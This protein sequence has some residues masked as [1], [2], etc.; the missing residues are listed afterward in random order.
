VL[1][2]FLNPGGIMSKLIFALTALY[3][4]N[5]FAFDC[6]PMSQITVM[7]SGKVY[8]NRGEDE[9]LLMYNRPERDVVRAALEM[10]PRLDWMTCLL[11]EGSA[12]KEVV[13]CTKDTSASVCDDD[14][15]LLDTRSIVDLNYTDKE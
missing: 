5:A 9:K 15:T 10:T 12:I 7:S 3:S 8:V 11:V 6:R 2:L 1:S 13:V 4:M 14:G